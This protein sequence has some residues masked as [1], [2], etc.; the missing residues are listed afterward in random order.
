[1]LCG[2]L[3]ASPFAP[4]WPLWPW[5]SYAL[6]CAGECVERSLLVAGELAIR[7]AS[8]SPKSMAPPEREKASGRLRFG[9]CELPLP[10][11][12]LLLLLELLVPVLLAPEEVEWEEWVWDVWCGRNMSKPL[13]DGEGGLPVD[14]C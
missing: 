7:L 2:G 11:L 10:L 8:S 4:P 6:P 1:M 5:L 9:K 13:A 14:G 12:L 3:Y